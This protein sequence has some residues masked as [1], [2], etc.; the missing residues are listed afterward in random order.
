MQVTVT[1]VADPSMFDAKLT[2]FRIPSG[3]ARVTAGADGQ[4]PFAVL[5]RCHDIYG[6]QIL[7]GGIAGFS[8]ALS[9]FENN[10]CAGVSMFSCEYSSCSALPSAD[11]SMV[12]TLT[13]PKAFV[14]DTNRVK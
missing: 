4:Y 3:H 5:A 1:V 7:T 6:N 11:S 10:P 13:A 8:V 12:Y 9:R 2:T 14:G